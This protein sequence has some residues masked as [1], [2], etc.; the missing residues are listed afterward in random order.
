MQ[1]FPTWPAA[2]ICRVLFSMSNPSILPSFFNVRWSICRLF[3]IDNAVP[4]C[5]LSDERNMNNR[6]CTPGRNTVLRQGQPQSDHR[7]SADSCATP[8]HNQ[9]HVPSTLHGNAPGGN[10]CPPAPRS[11]LSGIPIHPFLAVRSDAKTSATAAARA[12]CHPPSF[13]SRPLAVGLSF[14]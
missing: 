11:R 8:K 13:S 2:M 7:P 4:G 1:I 10:F 12:A 9:K 6:A 5:F 14:L 3:P